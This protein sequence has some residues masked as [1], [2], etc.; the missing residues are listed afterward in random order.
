M[1]IRMT[2]PWQPATSALDHLRG[3]LGVFQLANAEQEVVYIGFAGARSTFG[4][5]GEVAAA[6]EQMDT[7]QHG[8]ID[9]V[10]WEVTTAY[11]TRHR[12]LLM[13]HIAD[14]HGLPVGNSPIP[15]GKLSPA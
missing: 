6:I 10:R 5:R 2:K 9:F 3:N 13:V 14:Y 4:L 7:T 12:E 11:R 15:L 8:A 1:A